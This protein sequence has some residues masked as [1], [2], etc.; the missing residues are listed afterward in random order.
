VDGLFNNERSYETAYAEHLGAWEKQIGRTAA[1]G[2]VEDAF[3]RRGGG[4]EWSGP[5]NFECRVEVEPRS[6]SLFTQ[7][8]IWSMSFIRQGGDRMLLR[9]TRLDSLGWDW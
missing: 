8:I 1:S 4:C 3:V 5:L 6:P 9:D 7:R 2:A